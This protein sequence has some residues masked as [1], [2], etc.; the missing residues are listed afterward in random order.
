[1]VALAL[2]V[3]LLVLP[4]LLPVVTRS[5]QGEERLRLLELHP[6]EVEEYDP[7][8]RVTAAMRTPGSE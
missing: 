4:G 8:S 1:M 3:S 5:R 2:L 7:H 6:A